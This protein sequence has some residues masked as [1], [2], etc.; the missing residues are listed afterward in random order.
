MSPLY[1]PE[2]VYDLDITPSRIDVKNPQKEYPT[3]LLISFNSIMEP[4]LSQI[5]NKI[6]NYLIQC[7]QED[8]A[9]RI[10]F[11]FCID[12]IDPS[13]IKNYQQKFV[14]LAE[15]IDDITS[16]IE[17]IQINILV[18]GFFLWA[19]IPLVFA[20]NTEVMIS[21]FTDWVDLDNHLNMSNQFNLY[22]ND[23]KG[24]Y[25]VD[26]LTID[27]LIKLKKIKIK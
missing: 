17:G 20:N 6:Y 14:A 19:M 8:V 10:T 11:V 13:I 24:E 26:N 21:K 12:N 9:P 22:L 7:K 1:T 2:S 4:T 5:I 27:N 25:D 16:Q 3:E 23:K 18:R 15:Y